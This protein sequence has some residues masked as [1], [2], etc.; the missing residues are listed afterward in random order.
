MQFYHSRITDWDNKKSTFYAKGG[1]TFALISDLTKGQLEY[2]FS[3][4]R[5]ELLLTTGLAVCSN[6]DNYNRSIGREVS[7]KKQTVDQWRIRSVSW[8]ENNKKKWVLCRE[9]DGLR[10]FLKTSEKSDKVYLVNIYE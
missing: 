2:N 6:K 10:M 1:K 4:Y 3:K 8:D 5:Q 7:I 9:S